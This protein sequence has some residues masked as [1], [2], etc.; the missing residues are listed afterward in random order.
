MIKNIKKADK[1]IG[2]I[3]VPGDKS[4][5]H[6]AI[7]FGA[8]AE[9]E[10]KIT[11]FLESEDCLSTIRCVRALGVKVEKVNENYIVTGKGIAGLKEP[12]DI[13][14]C[15]NS[16]TT[17][18]LLSGLIAGLGFHAIMTGD[19]SLKKRP[20]TRIKDPLELMGV[21]FDGREN[22]KYAPISLRGKNLKAI[23]YK[24]PV[25]SAQVKSAILL[26]GLNSEGIT[27][28]IEEIPSRDHT[29]RM[30]K[31]F[32]ADISVVENEDANE[33]F[34]GEASENASK[35]GNAS[36]NGNKIHL[37]KSKLRAIEVNVPGDISSAAFFMAA[38][39]A[40]PGADLTIENVG[41]NPAR[42]G[43][44]HALRKMGANIQILNE[45]L[46]AGEPIGDI[47]VKGSKLKG[48]EITESDIPSMVDEIPVL[49]AIAAVAEGDTIIT[50]AQELK[51]KESDRIAVMASELTK[52]GVDVE[53]LSDGLIIR[54]GKKIRGGHIH[55][56]DDHRIAM[57][58]AICGLFSEEGIDIDGSEAVAISFPNFFEIIKTITE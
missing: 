41:L 28:I 18:R 13:L 2:T 53:E 20:M 15:G 7:M 17:I 56:H 40:F 29:E 57:S 44:I 22:G 55:S 25:A 27:E 54:G 10:T 4:I 14:D 16:G 39:A 51:V 37:K 46:T 50:G 30:L 3:S 48:I 9:G 1:I 36:K 47:R 33:N 31:S 38:A 52:V 42:T 5:S 8:L 11:G 49:A 23:S 34:I 21:H 58:M 24:M 12:D 35:S 45:R 6:R 32:G 43:I 19:S 26:A